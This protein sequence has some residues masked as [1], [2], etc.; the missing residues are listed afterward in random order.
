MRIVEIIEVVQVIPN[1]KLFN[2]E[3]DVVAPKAIVQH[4][5][6]LALL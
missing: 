3:R 1:S 4:A 5:E 6:D 2:K